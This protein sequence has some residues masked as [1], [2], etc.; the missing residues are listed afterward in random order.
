MVNYSI[1]EETADPGVKKK[2]HILLSKV[3]NGL[4]K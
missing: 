2:V 4:I 1:F 3:K